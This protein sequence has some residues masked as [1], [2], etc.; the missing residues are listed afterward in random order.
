M[1]PIANPYSVSGV[2]PGSHVDPATDLGSLSA[3]GNRHANAD[4]DPDDCAH[5]DSYRYA[6]VDRYAH[7]DS[8]GNTDRYGY[9]YTDRDSDGNAARD[10]Y[11]DVHLAA[12]DIADAD[13]RQL[14][15]GTRGSW[16]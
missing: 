14:G 1:H 8:D 3:S 16:R 11:P 12:R 15:S 13:P 5:R 9:C 2:E 4:G 7:T 6:S 10:A